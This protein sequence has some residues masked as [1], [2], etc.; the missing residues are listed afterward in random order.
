MTHAC[1]STAEGR[2]RY[3][4]GDPRRSAGAKTAAP[5]GQ[6]Q[7]RRLFAQFPRP[8]HRAR[9]L[10]HAGA[11]QHRAVVRRR[12]RGGRD[13]RGRYPCK[14]RR[15]G[16]GLLLPALAGR[17]AEPD[18][19]GQ[20]AR[21]L[22]RRHAGRICRAGRGRRRQTPGASVARGGRDAALRRGDRVARHDGARQADRRPN[23]AAARHRR[24]LDLRPAVRPRHGRDADHHLVERRQ[25]QA[26][27]NAR[28]RP[29]H[30]LQDHAGLGKG[31]GRLTPAAAA[32]T[33]SSKSAA[34]ARYS[35]R[36]AP[37]AS[38]ARSR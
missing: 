20:R 38:A 4:V 35:A 31:G 34:P 28:R 18:R 7:G 16:R 9:H 14:G 26:R 17:R 12:R 2:R 21:R 36:S 10:P 15:Q 13:R 19:A 32:S 33:R 11:R 29:H 25:A 1:L 23:R 3:R 27:Q 5:P 22:D 24:R 6:G 37:S 30:Q 8:R